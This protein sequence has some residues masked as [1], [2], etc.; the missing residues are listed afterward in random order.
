MKNKIIG[1]ILLALVAICV[2]GCIHTWRG[3]SHSV[4][5]EQSKYTATVPELT[6]GGGSREIMGSSAGGS[7]QGSTTFYSAEESKSDETL[8]EIKKAIVKRNEEELFMHD[9]MAWE[10][11]CLRVGEAV[12][13]AR[14]CVSRS[15]KLQKRIDRL[16]PKTQGSKP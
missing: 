4:A 9:M 5:P 14:D 11:D 1:S 3:F 7:S 15:D 8:R 10:S 2:I 12:Q 16:Q 6:G 13:V